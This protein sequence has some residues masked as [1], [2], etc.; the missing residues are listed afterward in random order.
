MIRIGR[1]D[2]FV[3][4]TNG[5][6]CIAGKVFVCQSYNTNHSFICNAYNTGY[7]LI[8]TN[9][10]A[11]TYGIKINDGS[12]CRT[13]DSSSS[14]LR[15]KFHKCKRCISTSSAAFV[16]KAWASS[17]RTKARSICSALKLVEKCISYDVASTTVSGNT[18][19]C[20]ACTAGFFLN[21]DTDTC[22]ARVNQLSGCIEYEINKDK[23]KVCSAHAF[24]N[25][26]IT[27]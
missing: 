10:N 23:C 21:E 18:Y 14:G 9:G 20:T 6:S 12:N 15:G 4:A 1:N 19:L 7:S 17:D 13:L 5:N 25:A 3:L 8:N 16:H 22:V 24:I 11:K 27:D 2:G 26:D